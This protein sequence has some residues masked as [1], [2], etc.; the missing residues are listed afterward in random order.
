MMLIR[1]SNSNYAIYEEL[2]GPHYNRWLIS[3][4]V[5]LDSNW[6]IGISHFIHCRGIM[7]IV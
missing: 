6:H 2:C 3:C 7:S 1:V 5:E 4:T